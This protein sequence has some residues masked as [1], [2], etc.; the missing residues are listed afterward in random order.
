MIY[1]VTAVHNRKDISV[2]FAKAVQASG[3][4]AYKL[5]LVDD[6]STDGTAEAVGEILGDNLIV[7]QG[8]GNLWWGG[9]LHMAYRWLIQYA[10][11]ED[12]VLFSND[13]VLY[14][15]E[16]IR[17]GMEILETK[18]NVLLS[19]LGYSVS[20]GK[21]ADA[22]IRWNYSIAEGQPCT[23]APWEG[24]CVSTRSVFF[25]VKDLKAI[26]GFHPVLLPHYA[27]DYEWTIR[28]CRK[29][30]KVVAD[31]RLMYLFDERTTGNRDR[32]QLSLKKLF[33][34]KSNMNPIYRINFIVLT[35]PAR[36]LFKALKRQITRLSEKNKCG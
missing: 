6:G 35:T 33:S 20:S 15:P 5:L 4:E 3:L 1:I 36:Y 9:A 28:A 32:K 21:L 26:G 19:G 16:Y 2:S 14:G 22:P 30:Y 8:D 25:R 11:D 29:G 13:D 24:D 27:S 10:T 34:K 7:L 23:E 18:E 12:M 31:E 17:K